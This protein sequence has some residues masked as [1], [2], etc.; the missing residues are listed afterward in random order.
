MP[1]PIFT[2]EDVN[3]VVGEACQA[4]IDLLFGP[5]S[6]V[7]PEG[8]HTMPVGTTMLDVLVEFGFFPSKSEARRN[9]KREFDIA[10]GWS[11]FL[12]IG[13]KRRNIFIWKP[14]E[15]IFGA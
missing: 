13:K 9:W 4:D 11:E 15:P 7:I 8:V 14:V 12:S 1:N 10:D 6:S 5:F 2:N 3:I